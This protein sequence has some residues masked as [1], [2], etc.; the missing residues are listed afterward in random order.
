MTL[1]DLHKVMGERINVTLRDDLTAE[2][3]TT[4]NEQTRIIVSVGK[5]MI[6]NGS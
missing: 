3:R 1:V 6:N 5:Q 2:E 4:E